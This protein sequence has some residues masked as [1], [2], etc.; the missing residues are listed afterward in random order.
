MTDQTPNFN[1]PRYSMYELRSQKL[2]AWLIPDL[3]YEGQIGVMWGQPGSCKSF[4]AIALA[5]MIAQG[6]PWQGEDIDRGN[7]LYVAGEGASMMYL[8]RRA[9][10][11]LH[12]MKEADDGFDVVPVAPNLCDDA[13]VVAFIEQ[14]QA[15]PAKLV[16][17]DTLSMCIPGLREEASEVMTLAMDNAKRI[18]DAL[19]C[20]ILFIHHPGK[21]I[22]RGARGHSSLYGNADMVSRVD[23]S[24]FN[25]SLKVEKQKDGEDGK[26]FNFSVHKVSTEMYDRR[27]QERTS[28]AVK[29]DRRIL[30]GTT[31]APEVADRL[32]IAAVMQPDEPLSLSALAPRVKHALGARSNAIERIKAAIPEE[33]TRT[34]QGDGIV[35]LRRTDGVRGAQM[36]EMRTV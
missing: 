25:V 32:S 28:L 29:E 12:G 4:L 22:G 2:P 16:I 18:R 1:Y 24:S 19:N 27:G 13:A 30:P 20:A 7:V 9:W 36:I 34:R 35:E 3:L 14:M 15:K 21:D 26:T 31:I 8:R 5:S 11:L 23:R 10:F 6:K 17:F 33:W